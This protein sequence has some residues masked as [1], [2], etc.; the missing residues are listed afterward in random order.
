MQSSGL[1]K[2]YDMETR[3]LENEWQVDEM[4]DQDK[5]FWGFSTRL[6]RDNLIYVCFLALLALVYIGNVHSA[7]KKIRSIHALEETN[8]E[9]RWQFMSMKSEYNLLHRE[10]TIRERVRP[11]G[12]QSS[13]TAPGIIIVDPEMKP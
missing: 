6:L 10:A 3:K 1:L 13:T 8:R 2:R 5:G 12:L 4:L 9:L 11:L 7:E